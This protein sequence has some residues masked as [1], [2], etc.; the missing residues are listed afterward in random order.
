MKGQY[1]LGI[2]LGTSATK[3]ALYRTDGTLVAEATAEVP[4]NYLRPGVVEQDSDDFYR[5]AA[6]TVRCCVTESGVDPRQ[7]AALAFDSQMA[8]V[9]T[10][11]ENFN[12]ATHFD[13][14]LDMRCEPYI[15]Q[16]DA[17]L[18]GMITRLSGCAPT[19]DHGPKILWWQHEQPEAYERIA[20]FLM[21]AMSRKDEIDRCREALS[22]TPY[23]LSGL[24]DAR[25]ARSGLL[26]NSLG[27]DM[28]RLPRRGAV[29]RR[30]GSDAAAGGGWAG[31]G[32]L[33]AE[34]RRYGRGAGRGHRAGRHVV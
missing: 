17:Q 14:W 12:P 27:V 15:K 4:I 10:I 19:C 16:M 18:G 34:L 28:G 11:D 8:G 32:T 23:P 31:A 20:R 13:S 29:A 9:G 5:T 30:R 21:P 22:T 2:D 3:A 1:L 25:S 26:C 24:S 33:V 6:Q 7:I